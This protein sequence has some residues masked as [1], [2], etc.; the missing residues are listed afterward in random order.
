MPKKKSSARKPRTKKGDIPNLLCNKTNGSAFILIGG[1]RKYLGRYGS[2][3]AEQARLKEWEQ[4]Q[5]LGYLPGQEEPVT[6]AVLLVNFLKYA[7]KRYTKHDRSTGT[8]EKY[9]LI[10][11]LLKPFDMLP[12]AKFG[13]RTLS[14]LQDKMIDEKRLCRKTINER[15]SQVVKIFKWGVSKELVPVEVYIALST[16]EPIERGNPTVIN[17]PPVPE[18]PLEDVMKTIAVAHKVIGDMMRVQLYSAMRPQEVYMMRACDIDTSDDIWIYVPHEHKLEHKDKRRVIPIGPESQAILASYLLDNE[19]TPDAYLFSP[20]GA[21][22][23]RAIAR[24]KKRV[25]SLEKENREWKRGE[26]K[27]NDR[28]NKDS[29]RHAVIR[30]AK[31]AGVKPFSPNQLRHTM[32]TDVE[33][34]QGTEAAQHLLGHSDAKTTKIY[35]DPDADLKR[36]VARVKEVARKIVVPRVDEKLS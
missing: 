5:R 36:E 16:V 6:V 33:G 12:V 32:A 3:E 27:F 15:I 29:Y 21:M 20:A 10:R 9:V 26:G 24:R 1:A 14:G 25:K 30:A 34:K 18:A 13:P 28:Y 2:I 11:D 23:I 4:Y 22:K 8:W 17:R 31:K 19:D 7:A 35:I